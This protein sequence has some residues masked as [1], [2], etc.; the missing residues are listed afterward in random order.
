MIRN[1]LKVIL[2]QLKKNKGFAL[3]NMFG[4]SFGL[5]AA[6]LILLWIQDEVSYNRFHTKYNELYQVM[7]NQKYDSKTYT[8][9]ATPGLLAPAM[10]TDFPEVAQTA[11]M[12]WGENW[13]FTANEKTLYENGNYTDPAFF[14]MFTFPK[15]YGDLNNPFPDDNSIVL[16]E[17]LAVKY[18]GTANVVGKYIRINNKDDFKITAVVADPPLNSSIKFDWLVSFRVFEKRNEWLQSWTNNGV[19]TYV[20]LKPGS[21]YKTFNTK[22][23][24]YIKSKNADAAAMPLL[25][26]MDDWRLRSTFEEGVQAGGRIEYIRLFGVIAVLLIVIACINFMNLATARS[27]QRAKEVGVRKVMGAQR[28]TLMLQFIG[29]SIVMAFLAMLTACLLV[30]ITLPWFNELVGKKLSTGFG[31]PM[32]WLLLCGI[33]VVCGLVAGSYP[34]VYL[35]SFK[36]VAIFKGIRSG[37]H[38]GAGLIRKGLVITQ[39]VVSIVLIVSTVVIY[40]QLGYVKNRQLGYNKDHLVYLRQSGKINEN[41]EPIINELRASGAVTHAASSNQYML[42]IGNNSAGFDW[43]GKDP[44]KEVLITTEFVSSDYISTAGMK[45]KAGRDFIQNSSADSQNVIINESFA[46]LL[47]SSDPLSMTLLRDSINYRIVGVINDFVYNDVY[48]SAPAPL[49]LFNSPHSTNFVFMRLD[50]NKTTEE[51][52]AKIEAV[53]KNNNPGYP[54][55]CS[56]VDQEFDKLFKS[57][58]LVS[59]LSRLFAVITILISCIG[60][61]GLAAYTAER[62]TRE[63]GIRK[64]LG[65]T[66]TGITG[67]LSVDFLK[68]VFIAILIAVPLSW[69]IMH[70]WL[71]DFSYRIDMQWWMFALAGLLALLIAL[72]TVSFQAIRAAISNPVKSI[73][74]E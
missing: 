5:T 19:Q 58:M 39:F 15:L 55:E 45:L 23:S 14:S 1:Y 63:I 8:F 73:R 57:E 25:L 27:E 52:L 56:F 42:Q 67:L 16:T 17:K 28:R 49:V 66:V 72:F 53:F 2:R 54:F 31:N 62:R 10:K 32:Q 24:N 6:V 41:L 60:L 9:A 47:G 4:L 36:P 35:S 40:G 21:D 64:I 51:A 3:L 48:G 43:Q 50:E 38:S 26:A 13:L 69:Y 18:F 61:F 37:R 65:A 33:A 20:V 44:T 74:T 11:R 71:E 29:E 12:C 70:K 46:K 34:S 22:F 7:G 59:K 30:L 68:L